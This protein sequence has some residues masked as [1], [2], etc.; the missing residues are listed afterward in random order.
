MMQ[1]HKEQLKRKKSN[2]VLLGGGET[3]E[4]KSRRSISPLKYKYDFKSN[5]DMFESDRN[6]K[7]M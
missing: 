5:I 6:K 4:R 1:Y 3:N 7:D 2:D